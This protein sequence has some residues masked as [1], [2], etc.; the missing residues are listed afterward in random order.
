M[1]SWAWGTGRAAWRAASGGYTRLLG[2]QART[3]G[4]VTAPRPRS[5]G[6]ELPMGHGAQAFQGPVGDLPVPQWASGGQG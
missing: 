4:C 5:G 2:H 6:R 1:D 3:C